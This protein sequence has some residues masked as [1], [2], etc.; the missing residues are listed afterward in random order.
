MSLKCENSVFGE[1]M[2]FL[3]RKSL[4]LDTIWTRTLTVYVGNKASPFSSSA[5]CHKGLQVASLRIHVS[6]EA[7][8]G[9]P[10]AERILMSVFPPLVICF[11]Q[12]LISGCIS[13]RAPAHS[14]QATTFCLVILD[15]WALISLSL[16]IIPPAY[17]GAVVSCCCLSLGYFTAYPLPGFSA[18]SY[19]LN[20]K[21]KSLNCKYSKGL[22]S[23]LNPCWYKAQ[24]Q[25]SC[26]TNLRN[27]YL[28]MRLCCFSNKVQIQYLLELTIITIWLICSLESFYFQILINRKRS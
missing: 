27:V 25:M 17:E 23:W 9:D 28:I 12:R 2:G 14:E 13:C 10:K 16:P 22:F 4:L 19:L 11:G 20:P 5:L 18:T 15:L 1:F 3:L 7:L 24:P 6:W 8:V 21:S 26:H